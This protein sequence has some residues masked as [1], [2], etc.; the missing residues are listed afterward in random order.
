MGKLS[1]IY[2]LIWY[3]DCDDPDCKPI[4]LT[5]WVDDI[6]FVFQVSDINSGW[7]HW[8]SQTDIINLGD[9]AELICGVPYVIK[10]KSDDNVNPKTEIEIPGVVVGKFADDPS[11]E[12]PNRITQNCVKVEDCTF[13]VDNVRTGKFDLSIH[14][15]TLDSS[16]TN[17]YIRGFEIQFENVVLSQSGVISH[18]FDEKIKTA[19][20][21]EDDADVELYRELV[22]RT[23]PMLS[24]DKDG[25]GSFNKFG[26]VDLRKF[27]TGISISDEYTTIYKFTIPYDSASGE[28]SVISANVYDTS[29]ERNKYDYILCEGVVVLATPTPT[30]TPTA[31]KTCVDVADPNCDDLVL[32]LQSD[33]TNG[34]TEVVDYSRSQHKLKF[35]IS[36]V[37]HTSNKRKYGDSSINLLGNDKIIELPESTDWNLGKSDFTIDAWVYIDSFDSSADSSR[38]KTIIGTTKTKSM[39]FFVD[40]TEGYLGLWNGVTQTMSSERVSA[41]RWTHIG[42]SRESYTLRM[43][44]DG[45]MCYEDNGFSDD[46]YET[47]LITIGGIIDYAKGDSS[48]SRLFNGYI[49]D[50]RIV[51]GDALY[52]KTFCPITSAHSTCDLLPTPTPTATETLEQA[53]PTP[54]PTQTETPTPTTLPGCC[55]GLEITIDVTQGVVD[56]SAPHIINGFTLSGFE[57]GGQ[58]CHNPM[59]NTDEPGKSH[60]LVL[61]GKQIGGSVSRELALPDNSRFV[62]IDP[63]GDC[64]ETDLEGTGDMIGDSIYNIL[65]PVN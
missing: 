16:G 59:K 10:L 29:I 63:N 11:D 44:V 43:F 51:K 65:T 45:V 32:H 48:Y 15:S 20:K 30:P 2:N 4:D 64:Y 49:N 26:F 57:V 56:A 23:S 27:S 6:E 21:N 8:S 28:I 17:N 42:F 22:K 39:V 24:F 40:N 25:N 9:F 37:T 53:T 31:T 36:Q 41:R 55:D 61:D 34:S 60:I 1:K 18:T 54:T 3:G 14:M 19:L 58:I 50:L 46:F 33:H 7:K 12:T 5:E 38:D 62:Y 47:E 13:L 35:P 52:T